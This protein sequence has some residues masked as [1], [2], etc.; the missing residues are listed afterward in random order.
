MIKIQNLYKKL[1]T[2]ITLVIILSA[3]LTPLGRVQA[4]TTVSITSPTSNSSVNGTSF[5]VT[6][7]ATAKRKITVTVNGTT[8]G[9]T[10]SDNSGNWSLNV[11]GQSAGA[12]T[13]EATASV[14]YAY[15][16][17]L[18][19]STISVINTVTDEQIGS[20]ISSSVG[21]NNAV[22]SPDGTQMVSVSGFGANAIKVW[23]LS[24]PEV[25]V[26]TH[27]LTATGAHAIAVNYTP[28][29]TYFYVSSEA[30]DFS[31]GTVTRY[32]SADPTISAAVTGYNQNFPAYPAMSSD[33][34]RV[35][36][37][38]VVSSTISV[39]NIATNT[40]LSTFASSGG[41]GPL[42]SDDIHGYS[43]S[44]GGDSA[45]PYNTQTETSGSAISV[46]DGPLGSAF[47][48]DQS[49]LLVANA[50]SDNIS[51]IN[52]NSNTVTDTIGTGAGSSPFFPAFTNDF[53]KLYVSES[54][55]DQISVRNPTTLATVSTIS[56]GDNPRQFDIGPD[57]TATTS[58]NF[59][60]TNS[61]L[62]GTGTN[63]ANLILLAGALIFVTSS[64]F[65]Y[66][67][68][69]PRSAK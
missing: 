14:S 11:T 50:T 40:Q 27:N 25:P 37:A 34:T 16:P 6:G 39:I 7:T 38:N 12:K 45:T 67:S 51:I 44:N 18:S 54:G 24:N 58:V 36:V 5:T 65:L 20:D 10:T 43:I 59:T 33:S 13:I 49:L 68:L 31:S 48:Q 15:V 19:A 57:Q 69:K 28:D 64:T 53:S 26:I 62:A 21:Q 22:V 9:T 17:N 42:K 35:Y 8:V 32:N 30:G 41:G 1:I 52:T 2:V 56:V 47:N 60:L 4:A 3:C 46:G 61:T 23:S 55:L 63:V 66:L 29:G